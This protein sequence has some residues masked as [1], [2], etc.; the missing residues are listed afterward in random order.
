MPN[1]T[2]AAGSLTDSGMKESPTGHPGATAP[3]TAGNDGTCDNDNLE[4]QNSDDIWD[5]SV[6][7]F[8]FAKGKSQDESVKD[9]QMNLE[10]EDAEGDIWGQTPPPYAYNEDNPAGRKLLAQLQDDWI[11]MEQDVS[12]LVRELSSLVVE[13]EPVRLMAAENAMSGSIAF[14]AALAGVDNFVRQ[15]L[16][17][18]G[19]PSA[20][21]G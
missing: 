11:V 4:I 13:L 6:S 21:R 5:K 16:E 17:S 14:D 18:Q 10:P 8:T 9:I 1:L 7:P 15:M 12:T 2:T 3:A 19:T 20:S